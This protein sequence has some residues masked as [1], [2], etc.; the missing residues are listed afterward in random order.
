VR[1]LTDTGPLPCPSSSQTGKLHGSVRGD[2]TYMTSPAPEPRIDNA[3]RRTNGEALELVCDPDVFPARLDGEDCAD[4]DSPAGIVL[5]AAG[6]LYVMSRC[7][8]IVVGERGIDV[9]NSFAQ[10]D[11]TAR[12]VHKGYDL[13]QVLSERA[14]CP[15]R[16]P[17]QTLLS[18]FPQRHCSDSQVGPT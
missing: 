16:H 15:A 11:Q 3:A 10:N 13:G 7:V 18:K 1:S 2:A 14:L 8:S 17:V 6:K 12:D 9:L 5:Q 4:L